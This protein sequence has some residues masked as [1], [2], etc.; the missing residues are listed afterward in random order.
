MRYVVRLMSEFAHLECAGLTDP[1]LRR[2]E[3][4]DA[5]LMLPKHGI[6]CVADGIGGSDAGSGASLALVEAVQKQFEQLPEPEIV[7]T[8]EGK[9]RLL[10][11]TI[12]TVSMWIK[13]KAEESG[14]RG[15]GTTAVMLLF[16]AADPAHALTL[17]AG[18][19]QA[20]RFRDR[21]LVQLT[22]DH[23][24]AEE[25]KVSNPEKLSP[26]FQSIITRAVGVRPEVEL[27]ENSIEVQAGDVFLLCSDGLTR[28][29]AVPE[30]NH[31]FNE[32]FANRKSLADFCRELVGSANAAGG[33]DNISI[34]LIEVKEG[35][36][37]HPA[38]DSSQ[39]MR[40]DLDRLEQ[41]D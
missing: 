16:D 5:I 31:L 41:T 27:E 6:F 32:A 26:R 4:Q 14:F 17:H 15:A 38:E 22:R 19:S 24:L 40:I 34:V 3:N 23:S 11:R 33:K 20:F 12:N 25:V 37:L 10:R 13:K 36:Q 2:R 7:R 28:M 18:D 35:G 9:A 21:S 29:V 8:S 30:L 1:G 39:T